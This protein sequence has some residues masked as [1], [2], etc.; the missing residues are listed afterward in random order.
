MH[1]LLQFITDVDECENATAYCG[2]NQVC[3][4][5]AGSYICECGIG[6]EAD[7]DSSTVRPG[8]YE[9]CKGN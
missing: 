7:R 8:E 1:I 3:F 9:R 4:N 6:Y 5:T 2:E